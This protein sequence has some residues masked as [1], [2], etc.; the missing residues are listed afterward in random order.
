[1]KK[2]FTMI[3]AIA[4]YLSSC[5]GAKKVDFQSSH[6]EPLFYIGD[7]GPAGGTIFFDKG[8]YS[9][10]WRYMEAAPVIYE[11]TT[12]WGDDL[13]VSG[14]DRYLGAGSQNTVY[15][16]QQ[17]GQ[18]G[19]AAYMSRKLSIGGFYDWFLPSIYEL[20]LMYLSL[21]IKNIGDFSDDTYWSST[22][23]SHLIAWDQCFAS[24]NLD[25]GSKEND[26]RVRPAR[27]F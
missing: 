26:L 15:I 1:M 10:G 23:Y 4:I 25:I 27:S 16:Y 14:T 2:T 17:L 21:K 8:F 3:L 13:Y 19:N 6:A 20:N 12:R 7:T 11:F 24:G 18:S 5:V 22:Q 9:D